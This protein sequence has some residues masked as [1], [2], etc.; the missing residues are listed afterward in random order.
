VVQEDDER[1]GRPTKYATLL[2]ICGDHV[3]SVHGTLE[4]PS[5]HL[6]GDASFVVWETTR[7]HYAP[8]DVQRD[9]EVLREHPLDG[10]PF[11]SCRR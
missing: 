10:C 5:G 2:T 8:G 4:H 9:A 6:A 3:G 7:K 1:T 11:S